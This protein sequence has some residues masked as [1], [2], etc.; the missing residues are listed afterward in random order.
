M[1]VTDL[2]PGDALLEKIQQFVAT[3]DEDERTMFATLIAPGVAAAWEDLDDV[4]GF[5]ADSATAD[6]APSSLGDHLSAAVRRRH[7]T[8][9]EQ[10]PS[11]Q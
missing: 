6:W 7:L 10:P 8:I 11:D 2:R 4:S 5:A 3:L 1:P 9:V